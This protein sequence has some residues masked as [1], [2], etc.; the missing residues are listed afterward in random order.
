MSESLCP[1]FSP[2]PLTPHSTLPL[3]PRAYS[4]TQH[5]TPPSSTPAISPVP[6]VRIGT[7]HAHAQCTR[8]A[9]HHQFIPAPRVP[10]AN[11]L[12]HPRCPWHLTPLRC[13]KVHSH[14]FPHPLTPPHYFH[15]SQSPLVTWSHSVMTTPELEAAGQQ[16]VPQ[17]VFPRQLF[18][19]IC[20]IVCPAEI[21]KLSAIMSEDGPGF[22]HR[23]VCI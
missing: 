9:W 4:S 2:A 11:T 5:L 10:T 21:R 14:L 6:P 13:L 15:V 20:L 19:L 17:T 7:S 3:Q 23:F 1:Q 18:W 22:S 8:S 16:Q 12:Q